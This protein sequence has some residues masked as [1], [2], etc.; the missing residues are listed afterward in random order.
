MSPAPATFV[1]DW[2]G[3]ITSDAIGAGTLRLSVTSEIGADPNR[4]IA[5]SFS[6]TFAAAGFDVRGD[7]TGGP[8]SETR[9]MG[10][11]FDRVR[12]P[13]PSEAGGGADRAMLAT[14]TVA[15]RRLTGRYVVAG[16]P[17]GA[18][19]ITKR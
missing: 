7:F 11:L 1:G 13:C 8:V 2:D 12:V 16:C 6:T 5:G 9:Q 4:L 17:G 18:I 19:D 15:G 3:T 14:V 10:L